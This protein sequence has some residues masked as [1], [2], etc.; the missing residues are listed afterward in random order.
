M[1]DEVSRGT[2][3]QC[4]DAGA[5]VFSYP[6]I[7]SC[8]S[9][10]SVLWFMARDTLTREILVSICERCGATAHFGWSETE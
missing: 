1:T 9:T 5:H 6:T 7:V 10:S 8:E 3:Q 4:H 2:Q